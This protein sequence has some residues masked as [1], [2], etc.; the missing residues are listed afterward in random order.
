MLKRLFIAVLAVALLAGTTAQLMPHGAMIAA[1]TAATPC[2]AMDM[3]AAGVGPSTVPADMPCKGKIPV[4]NDSIG[5]AVV[6]NLPTP[7]RVAPVAVRWTGI[8][9]SAAPSAL[10]GRTLEPEL[11]PP[12]AIA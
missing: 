7:V 2:E 3:P 9:W 8:V 5:C 10:A 4:C 11:T 6:F 1:A 12:I